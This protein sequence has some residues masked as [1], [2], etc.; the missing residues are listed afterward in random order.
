MAQQHLTIE[1]TY[2]D[3]CVTA[4]S[5]LLPQGSFYV[6]I[7]FLEPLEDARV[8]DNNS[9]VFVQL[10]REELNQMTINN[11][12][13]SNRELEI[14]RLVEKGYTNTKIAEELELGP[15]TIRNYISAL[16][17]KVKATNRTHLVALA[18]EKGLLKS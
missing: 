4:I 6:L 16:L 10:S 2:I 7:T 17:N 11:F 3:G 9:P 18:K 5:D 14:L 1:G 8:E 12:G 13:I 15:G